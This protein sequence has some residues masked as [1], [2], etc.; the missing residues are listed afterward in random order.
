MWRHFGVFVRKNMRDLIGHETARTLVNS[1]K[2]YTRVVE[3]PDCLTDFVQVLRGLI[4]EG[5]YLQPLEV[6]FDTFVRLRDEDIDLTDV[7]ERIRN[8][9][10]IIP[11]LPGN[12]NADALL[13]L[14]KSFEASLA[15]AIVRD[16]DNKHPVL[17]IEPVPCQEALNG[18]RHEVLHK[19]PASVALLVEDPDIRPFVRRLVEL[20][21][22]GLP[23]LSR[24]ELPAGAE[25]RILAGREVIPLPGPASAYA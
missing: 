14:S 4:R 19:T 15:A 5:V 6:I 23:V 3:S 22:P 12:R 16:P 20:E 9:P 24:R 8:R 25:A 7:V 2:S 11:S 1:M 21:L 10:E 13:K 17:A 18:V